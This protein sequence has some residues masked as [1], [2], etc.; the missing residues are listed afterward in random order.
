M[1]SRYLGALL[2]GVAVA[3]HGGPR[4]LRLGTTY[5]VQQSGALAVL[6]AHWTGAPLAVVV[7]PSG[8]IL[9]SAAQGDLDVVITH[10]P[11]LEA[12][13]L[14]TAHT[15]LRCPLVASRFAVVGPPDDPAPVAAAATPPRGRSRCGRPPSPASP[16][17]AS[18]CGTALRR[19][20]RRPAPARR[21]GRRPR[22]RP[23]RRAPVPAVVGAAR[24]RLD[25]R[26]PRSSAAAGDRTDQIAQ[27]WREGRGGELSHGVGNGADHAAGAG[28][29]RRTVAD[30]RTGRRRECPHRGRA[31]TAPL[32]S[33]PAPPA[34]RAARPG[35]QPGYRETVIPYP[36]RLRS[37]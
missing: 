2:T 37:V 21:P 23:R 3:C 5:T 18:A 11:A 10:A 22:D 14:G 26:R 36:A 33:G 28:P 12:R 29:A 16:C 1:H 27:G 4:P 17:S 8:Q 34:R 13:I 15:T 19:S 35:V 32:L 9:R 30:R 7:G 24:R 25:H 20:R 6:E 31:R